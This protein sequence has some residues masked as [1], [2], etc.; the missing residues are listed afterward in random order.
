MSKRI[1]RRD[2]L[3]ASAAAALSLPAMAD[4]SPWQIGCYTR[5]WDAFDYRVA[6]DG[7]AEA[8]FRDR[9]LASEQRNALGKLGRRHGVP[10][11]L[12]DRAGDRG[13]QTVGRK[14]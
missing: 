5:P 4:E 12:V 11:H 13:F 7:S 14:A 3:A 6:L 8:G 10:V 9:L 1:S 2:F